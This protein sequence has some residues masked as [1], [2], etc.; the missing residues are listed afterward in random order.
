MEKEKTVKI[1]S[2]IIALL[3]VVTIVL[4]S[5]LI[6]EKKEPNIEKQWECEAISPE[7]AQKD[8]YYKDEYMNEA[9]NSALIDDGSGPIGAIITKKD[10]ELI[11]S[12]KNQNTPASSL[13]H[14]EICAIEEAQRILGT[15]DLS[16]CILYT[17][18]EPCLMC[19]SAIAHAKIFKVYYAADFEDSKQYGFYDD[20]YYEKTYNGET[21]TDSVHIKKDNSAQPF[22]EWYQRK[23]ER[24]KTESKN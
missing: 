8:G 12:T 9:I 17:S 22:E 1:Q 18:A 24:K 3:V 13:R 11:V 5:L 23:L 4:T 19:A 10:G 21:L 2:Y 20:E 6:N 16:E 15:R 14:A 7:D